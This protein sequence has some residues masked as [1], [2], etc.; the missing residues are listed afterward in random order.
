M[1]LLNQT[2]L[3]KGELAVNFRLYRMLFY[4]QPCP[5]WQLQKRVRLS[6]LAFGLPNL[7]FTAVLLLLIQHGFLFSHPQPPLQF[8]L[9]KEEELNNNTK[10]NPQNKTPQQNQVDKSRN[11][12]F[13]NVLGLRIPEGRKVIGLAKAAGAEPSGQMRDEELHAIVA[14]SRFR[15]KYAACPEHIWELRC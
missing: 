11:T 3:Q 7:G 6:I 5:A 4:Y 10:Q 8:I 2:R 15:S 1:V 13:S 9:E 14:R 12:V